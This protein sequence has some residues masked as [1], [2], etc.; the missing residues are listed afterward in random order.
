AL[1]DFRQRRKRAGDFDRSRLLYRAKLVAR[2]KENRLQRPRWP[3]IRNR[4][5]R[6][7]RW[8]VARGGGRRKSGLGRGLAPHHF[9]AGWGALSARYRQCASQQDFGWAWPYHRTKLVAVINRPLGDFIT[10]FCHSDRS[11]GMERVRRATWT[12]A[13]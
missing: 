1:S 4:D 8:W 5:C 12:A 13:P 3:G 6:S 7:E 9:Y 11:G 2:W 10:D